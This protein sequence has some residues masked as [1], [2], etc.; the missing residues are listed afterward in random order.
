M[1]AA[2]IG[3]G[4]ALFGTCAF[5]W[6]STAGAQST[7][8]HR[9]NAFTFLGPDDTGFVS[10]SVTLG[11]SISNSLGGFYVSNAIAS[12]GPRPTTQVAASSAGTIGTGPS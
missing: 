11:G 10:T 8:T 1:R 4:L 3:I 5:G 9:A 6:S 2:W 7:A 12:G